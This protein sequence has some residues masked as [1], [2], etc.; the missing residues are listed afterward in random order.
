VSCYLHNISKLF[1][2]SLVVS[3]RSKKFKSKV[4]VF[5]Y[6]VYIAVP[7]DSYSKQ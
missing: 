2:R 1:L 4:S 3:T 6:S 7:Y 5:V